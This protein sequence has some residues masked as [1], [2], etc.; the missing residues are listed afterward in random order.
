ME[1]FKG[2]VKSVTETHRDVARGVREKKASL[3]SERNFDSE[4]RLLEERYR[5]K[6]HINRI[7]YTYN[8]QGNCVERCEF[9]FD[10]VRFFRY[11]YKYD[12]WGN[13]IE[14]QCFDPDGSLKHATTSKY[15]A[16][17][18]E[19]EKR[20]RKGETTETARYK[21]NEQNQI[22]EEYLSVNGKFDLRR[23]YRFDDHGNKIEETAFSQ[24]GALD[25]SFNQYKYDERG[26]IIEE[27]VMNADHEILIRYTFAYDNHNRRIQ[28]NQYD[29]DGNFSG[30][31]LSYNERGQL[32]KDRW[33]NSAT[34]SCGHTDF[35]FDSEGRIL[36]E[37]MYH[38]TLNASNQEVV[39]DDGVVVQ[40]VRYSFTNKI[41][42]YQHLHIYDAD[43]NKRECH[44]R[45]FDQEGKIILYK[46]QIFSQDGNLIEERNEGATIRFSYD[47][48]GN[49][50]RKEILENGKLMNVTERSIEYW[51]K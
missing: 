12:K 23:S 37:T 22:V 4:G 20:F 42:D 47:E 36:E 39:V 48:N 7:T 21:Y 3:V 15:N 9:D 28:R 45:H 14:E 49:W 17:G 10:K 32:T 30:S 11:K 25:S 16:E 43:G 6:K 31:T 41:T 8:R 5:R 51:D 33:Y 35:V 40:Q 26:N 1:Q 34:K 46:H 2:K 38:G 44:Q 50:I 13:Q 19:V 18:N 29:A 24:D 27:V